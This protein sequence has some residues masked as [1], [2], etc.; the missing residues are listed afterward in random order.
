MAIVRAFRIRL[1]CKVHSY[2]NSHSK[3]ELMVKPG[4]FF[5][6]Y[7]CVFS[8][9]LLPHSQRNVCTSSSTNRN[10]NHRIKKCTINARFR[11]ISQKLFAQQ[12]RNEATA[13]SR[14]MQD[15]NWNKLNTL[16]NSFNVF[17]CVH[18]IGCKNWRLHRSVL[19]TLL[20]LCA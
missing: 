4:S 7:K 2:R 13:P 18:F 11:N 9:A 20:W 1:T 6:W 19:C 17:F 3:C 5:R 10:K 12:R 8:I 15:R 14:K 16:K